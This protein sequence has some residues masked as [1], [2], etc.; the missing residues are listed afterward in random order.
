MTTLLNNIH[1]VQFIEKLK[2]DDPEL[3]Y[4][5]FKN[6]VLQK[7]DDGK[8]KYMLNIKED[9][10]LFIIYCDNNDNK[11]TD[12]ERNT[13]SCIFDKKTLDIIVT[14]YN[15][16]IYNENAIEYI[17]DTNWDNIMVEQCYEGTV[18]IL[19]YHEKWYISTRRCLDASDSSYIR[20][21]CYKTLFL[22]AINDKFS[23]D[24][25]DKN[26]C[27][28]FI[29]LN[30]KNKN[31]IN[32]VHCGYSENYTDII[33]FDT[34]KKYSLETVDYVITDK[35]K[36][37]EKMQ[38]TNLSELMDNV[39]QLNK[40][41]M[42]IKTITAEGYILKVYD[43]NKHTGLF[44][45]LKIQTEIYQKL[46]QL[47]P[48]NINMSQNYL[49]LYQKNLLNE[50]LP[51]F[52]KYTN[53]IINR[54]HM[55]MKNLSKE[56]LDLYHSTRQKKNSNL[57]NSL[58]DIYKKVLYGLHGLFIEFRKLSFKKDIKSS[59]SITIHDVYYYLKKLHP[60]QLKHIYLERSNMIKNNLSNY[61]FINT[62]CIY[63]LTL[64][65]LM[66]QNYNKK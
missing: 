58:P 54:I 56:F 6:I 16:I 52:T 35:V 19:F 50:H 20:N 36:K 3:D 43:N 42:G 46:I 63:T 40:H 1:I 44:K 17:K 13:K 21:R 10:N 7:N 24:D 34:T 45:L 5:K 49:E 23:L 26:M 59:K 25:L 62:D 29:L 66:F 2:K 47:K 31:I 64:T 22:E 9:D 11:Y 60:F 55:S 53:D 38:F 8:Q 27:Y 14:Q 41:D 28:K 61:S 57:Y 51:Y 39:S 32:Y 12:L 33:H 15:K 37:S 4:D 65:S 48:N 30:D 18:I